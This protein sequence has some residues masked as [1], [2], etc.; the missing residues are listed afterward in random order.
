MTVA[1]LCAAREAR[2]LHW[3]GP[4]VCLGCRHEWVAVAPEGTSSNLRCPSCD[5]PKG[6]AKFPFG[7]STGDTVLVCH[8]GSEALTA[9]QHG[10]R[11]YVRCMACGTDQTDVFFDA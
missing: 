4:A 9:Y 7:A 3:E 2:Q 1:S 11:L 6:T 5:L 8:C 10:G